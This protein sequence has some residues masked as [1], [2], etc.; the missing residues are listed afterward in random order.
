MSLKKF[1]NV[2]AYAATLPNF[3]NDI[4][5][6]TILNDYNFSE[7]QKSRSLM[8]VCFSRNM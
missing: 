8:M 1:G 7:A 2:A 6:L 4:F 5:R 3:F